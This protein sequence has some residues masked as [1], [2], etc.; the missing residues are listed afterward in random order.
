MLD[1][2]RAIWLEE[3]RVLAVAD[4]HLGYAWAHRLSGQMLPLSAREDS[5]ERLLSLVAD[6]RPLELLVLGDIV[7]KAVPVEA[8]EAELRSLCAEVTRHTTLRLIAGNHDKG[9]ALLLRQCG[10]EAKLLSAHDAGPH[11]LL[12]GDEK[13]DAAAELHFSNIRA[14]G[15]R[16]VMGHEHPAIHVGDGIA[17]IKCPCFLVSADLVIL[18]AFSQ[19]AA[20]AS[21]RTGDF[22]SALARA[23]RFDTAYAIMGRRLLPIE[24]SAR[25]RGR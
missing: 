19:W 14:R 6:Y 15:G 17:S 21:V 3:S 25:R 23:A 8:L 7:H 16:I 22:L 5:L 24:L 18:P 4:L 10:I 20:G 1:A 2:R 11:L 9:L 12:H 13:D